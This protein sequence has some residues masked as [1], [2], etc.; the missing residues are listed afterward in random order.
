MNILKTQK[1]INMMTAWAWMSW[2]DYFQILQATE[3]ILMVFDLIN[4]ILL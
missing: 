2:K 4:V 3:M 1:M